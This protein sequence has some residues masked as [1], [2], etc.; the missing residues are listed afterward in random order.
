MPPLAQ[1]HGQSAQQAPST[2][3]MFEYQPHLVGGQVQIVTQRAAADIQLAETGSLMRKITRNR[4]SADAGA[5][6]ML[7]I[8]LAKGS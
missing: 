8:S 3:P 7:T 5:P 4:S 1:Q 6:P 2:R